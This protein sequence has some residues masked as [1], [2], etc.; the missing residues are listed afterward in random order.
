MAVAGLT[1]IQLGLGSLLEPRLMGSTLNL[2]PVVIVVSL[3]VWGSLWGIAGMFLCV[4]IMVIITIVCAHFG[5]TRPI[6]IVLS[7]TGQLDDEIPGPP[8]GAG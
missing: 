2:S 6:A 1:A 3:A 7:G 8:P 4:P 5:P